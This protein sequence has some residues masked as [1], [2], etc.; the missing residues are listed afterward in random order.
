MAHRPHRGHPGRGWAA[1]GS[2]SASSEDTTC[3]APLQA[4]EGH[5]VSC[6]VSCWAACEGHAVSC[7]VSAGWAAAAAPG[8]YGRATGRASA[9]DGRPDAQGHRP[10]GQRCRGGDAG[11]SWRPH[12]SAFVSLAVTGSLASSVTA[13]GPRRDAAQR[14][15]DVH[16]WA[17][18]G[19]RARSR[20]P[21]GCA[22]YAQARTDACADYASGCPLAS[23]ART[24]ACA[25]YPSGC[26]LA[27][28]ART[29]A[30]ADYASSASAGPCGSEGWQEATAAPTTTG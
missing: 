23:P 15:S 16:K 20:G 19:T 18:T 22:D 1:A 13:V 12:S 29:D 4:C 9:S 11:C 10:G 8:R 30:C 27:S 24:D 5:A 2:Q 17:S 6:A 3:V 21:S 7:A 26:P 28:P 14:S 25:D